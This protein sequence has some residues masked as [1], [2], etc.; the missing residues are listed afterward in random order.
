MASDVTA[1]ILPPVCPSG[2]C[3]P[4]DAAQLA[5]DLMRALLTGTIGEVRLNKAEI[6]LIA[7]ALRSYRP[8]EY[9]AHWGS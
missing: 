3:A 8:R 9:S 5:E 6:Q 4:R 1:T 2:Y 7:Q